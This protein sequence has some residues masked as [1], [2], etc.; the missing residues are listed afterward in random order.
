MDYSSVALNMSIHS[1]GSVDGI[2]ENEWHC[3]SS[4]KMVLNW[5]LS[6]VTSHSSREHALTEVA[7]RPRVPRALRHRF[8]LILHTV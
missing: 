2:R 8:G 5:I 6:L 4:C 7:C 1:D 3:E